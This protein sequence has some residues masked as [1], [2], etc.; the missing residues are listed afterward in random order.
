MGDRK[1]GVDLG[2]FAGR[3]AGLLFGQARFLSFTGCWCP[4]MSIPLLRVKSGPVGNTHGSSGN[5]LRES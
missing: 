5:Q 3:I 1:V 2:L 4:L